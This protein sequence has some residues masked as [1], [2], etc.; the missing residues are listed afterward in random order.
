MEHGADEGA[1]L[2]G[3]LVGTDEGARGIGEVAL[4]PASS[5]I[6]RS[7]ALFYDM[8][9]LYL[10]NDWVGYPMRKD[11][12]PEKDNPLRMDNEETVDTKMCIRDSYFY[13]CI[14]IH[15]FEINKPFTFSEKMMYQL[16]ATPQR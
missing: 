4:V 1:E 12:E 5:P 6:N 10:R 15:K 13:R 8:R 9:R 7:G 16:L 3:Q 2:L 14:K 11:N